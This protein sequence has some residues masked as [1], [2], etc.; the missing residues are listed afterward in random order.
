MRIDTKKYANHKTKELQPNRTIKKKTYLFCSPTPYLRCHRAK[1][2]FGV[3]A[4]FALL[5]EE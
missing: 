4:S 5:S 1:I 3:G 2:L